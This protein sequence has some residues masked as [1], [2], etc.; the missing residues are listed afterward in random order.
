MT[1]DP[2]ILSTSYAPRASSQEQ[3]E[4]IPYEVKPAPMFSPPIAPK[5]GCVVLRKKNNIIYLISHH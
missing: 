4:E 3:N 5:G 1:D 2:G